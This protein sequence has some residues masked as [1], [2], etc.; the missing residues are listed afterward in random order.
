M[1]YHDIHIATTTLQFSDPYFSEHYCSYFFDINFDKD[2]NLLFDNLVFI[3][4]GK[5]KK[6]AEDFLKVVKQYFT[7]AGID[8]TDDVSVL[9]S[10]S[11]VLAIS[12]PKSDLW[13]DVR[14]GIF[15]HI[16]PKNFRDLGFTFSSFTVH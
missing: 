8:E 11:R 14:E 13:I 16:S 10:D 2:S 1:E 5:E 12:R 7:A 9:F 6:S 3:P 15:P 4:A